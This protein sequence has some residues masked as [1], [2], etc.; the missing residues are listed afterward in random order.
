MQHEDSLAMSN[1]CSI[2]IGGWQFHQSGQMVHRLVDISTCTTSTFSK[3]KT[4]FLT[5]ITKRLPWQWNM[6]AG[7]DIQCQDKYS[8]WKKMI[9][10][11]LWRMTFH[12][13]KA[14][15]YREN[16]WYIQSNDC[17][18]WKCTL[19]RQ[20]F[21][22]LQTPTLLHSLSSPLSNEP[23][24]IFL[25]PPFVE[26][27]LFGYVVSR[28][29]KEERCWRRHLARLMVEIMVDTMVSTLSR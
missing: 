22:H 24:S 14:F 20:Y 25:A 15:F 19:C 13:W 6:A 5:F 1:I 16:Y 29:K 7:G 3:P 12:F 8:L 21:T 2:I 9:V 18:K 4:E 11:T 10:Q 28:L 26:L 27:V 17:S 23:N